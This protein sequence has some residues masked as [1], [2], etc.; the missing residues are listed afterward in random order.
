MNAILTGQ[1][2]SR[3]RMEKG[4]T[5]KEL[6]QRVGVTDKAVSKWETGRGMPDISSLDALCNALDVS[7][8]EL[9]SG[10]VLPPEFYEKKAEENMKTL[11]KENEK[12]TKGNWIQMI[13]GEVLVI[14]AFVFL[15]TCIG[16]K[17]LGNYFD[18]PSLLYLVL[19]S[20]GVVLLSR[21]AGKRE[22]FAAL[23]KAVIPAGALASV[24]S[25]I[26]I[27]LYVED[28]EVIFANFAVAL[29]PLAYG[30]FLYLLLLP[31]T[32]HLKKD[33]E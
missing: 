33:A 4:M 8:N 3:V 25:L 24:I 22:I 10:E 13:L 14:V 23:Q 9:L 29:L 12:N 5:Q 15:A 27:F 6:A 18:L 11:I 7:V 2:I 19:I 32:R 28:M 30:I 16:I 1:F 21:P 20:A 17:M 26:Q 31:I